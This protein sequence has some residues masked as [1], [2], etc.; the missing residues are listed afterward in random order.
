[1]SGR[2]DGRVAIVTG[3]GSGIGAAIVERFCEEGARVVAVDISGQQKALAA[4]IGPACVPFHADVSRSADVAAMLQ[5]A[6]ATFG[7]VDILCNNAGIEGPMLQTADYSEDDYERVMEVN[8]RGVFL[9]MR[10]AIPIMLAHGGGSIVNTASMASW[11]AFPQMVGYCA[12]KGAVLAMTR[13]TAVEY[14]DRNIRIN[15]VC[16]GA[17][18][19][20]ILN[21]LPADYVQA[22]EAAAPMKRAGDPAEIANAVLFLASDEASFVTGTSLVVDGGYTAN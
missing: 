13:T 22:V 7:A 3:A 11:V 6:L 21:A 19:T 2:L 15:C 4:R 9:G 14:A 12:T 5:H 16:P 17:V 1:M 20:A 10:H 8:A 18:K